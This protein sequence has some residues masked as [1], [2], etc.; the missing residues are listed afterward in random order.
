MAILQENGADTISLRIT[1]QNILAARR[2]DPRYNTSHNFDRATEFSIASQKDGVGLSFELIKIY[3]K[4]VDSWITAHNFDI[5]KKNSHLLS[6]ATK[7]RAVLVSLAAQN[8]I[9]FDD[10][11]NPKASKL[12]AALIDDHRPNAWF[13]I[14]YDAIDSFTPPHEN[15]IMRRLYESELFGVYDEGISHN[16]ISREYCK[17]LYEAYNHYKELL[18]KFE[19]D[20]GY[21]VSKANL[22]YRLSGPDHIRNLE[23]SFSLAYNHIRTSPKAHEAVEAA[24]S[25][26]ENSMDDLRDFWS[27]YGDQAL[28]H[29]IAFIR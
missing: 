13:T 14:R 5:L 18:M 27:R 1:V 23:Q 15:L 2:Q 28:D 19:R 17:K 9:G 16:S 24:V 4:T 3:E 6:R 29:E 8:Y 21:L 26:M 22:I 20:H 11:G 12:A 25:Y 7:E 10:Q